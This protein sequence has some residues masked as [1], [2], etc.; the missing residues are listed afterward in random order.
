MNLNDR[1]QYVDVS[2]KMQEFIGAPPGA[3]GT[4]VA[5]K[6][7][8]PYVNFDHKPDRATPV[9]TIDLEVIEDDRHQAVPE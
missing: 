8:V 9:M 1:V 7:K 2:G 5:F 6:G 3:K 4:I